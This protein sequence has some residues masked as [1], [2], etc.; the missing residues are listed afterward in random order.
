MNTAQT[1]IRTDS[2][3]LD[4]IREIADHNGRSLSAECEVALRAHV[5]NAQLAMAYDPGSRNDPKVRARLDAEPD[6]EDRLKA[7]IRELYAT[8]FRRR[9]P[10]DLLNKV[11]ETA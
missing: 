6:F 3:T 4:F 9:S 8:A 1:T 5:K 10:G 11:H 2:R 7:E